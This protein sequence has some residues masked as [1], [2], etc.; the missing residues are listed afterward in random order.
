[1]T[2]QHTYENSPLYRLFNVILFLLYSF[3]VLITLLAGYIAYSGRE[4]SSA[5]VKCQD[6]TSWGATKTY[7]DSY[8]LCGQCTQRNSDGSKYTPCNWENMSYS[9]YEV[10]D[11]KYNWSWWIILAPLIVF[12]VGF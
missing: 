12:S 7:N 2:T 8:A 5:N 9:S 10:V 6:G 4:V 3:V 1:M 11:K